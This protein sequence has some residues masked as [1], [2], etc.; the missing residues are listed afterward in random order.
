MYVMAGLLVIG[1]LCNLAIK[2]VNSRH[3]MTA[4]EVEQMI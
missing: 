1:F 2:A 4:D 3:H